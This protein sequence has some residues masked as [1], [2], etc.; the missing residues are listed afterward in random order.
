MLVYEP[1]VATADVKI[2]L[3]TNHAMH[4][5]NIIYLNVTH[6]CKIMKS[7]ITQT[8]MFVKYLH[9]RRCLFTE[10]ILF[11]NHYKQLCIRRVWYVS[12]AHFIKVYIKWHVMKDPCCMSLWFNSWSSKSKLRRDETK[13][14]TQKVL[15]V[16]TFNLAHRS[17]YRW[18]YTLTWL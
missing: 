16:V 12:W 11:C 5:N 3:N 6:K 18:L 17:T 4:R 14:Q 15:H 10:Y 7:F 1:S 8:N 9:L 2:C 13:T